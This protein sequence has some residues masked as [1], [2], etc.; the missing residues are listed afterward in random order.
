MQNTHPDTRRPNRTLT[1][2]RISLVCA[3]SALTACTPIDFSSL[4]FDLRGNAPGG[5]DTSGA[6]RNAA[7][8]DRP[9]P[10]DSGLITYPTYQVAVAKRGD[11]VTDVAAR[12][13]ISASEL[14]QFNGRSTDAP[15]RAGEILAMPRRVTPTAAE[16]PTEAT[17]RPDISAIAGA[18]IDRANPTAPAA[19][20]ATAPKLEV[21]SGKE[22]IRHRAARGE[23]AFTIARLY[24]VSVKSLAEW[25]GLGS[26]LEVR[27]GQYLIIPLILENTVTA[28]QAEAP[29]QGTATPV[30][31]SA[32]AALPEPITEAP[33][34]E[35]PQLGRLQ[36]PETQPAAPVAPTPAKP[37][38]AAPSFRKP[39]S[40]TLGSYSSKRQAVSIATSNG[41]AV[42][43]AA[44][45]EVILITRDVDQ[46]PVIV[47]AHAGDLKSVYANIKDARVK[48][49]DSISAGQ[50]LAVVNGDSF[51]FSVLRGV[52]PIDPTPLLR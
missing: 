39:V 32:A 35:S 26:D 12:V 9:K 6:A 22:P 49:G 17:S 3:V 11:T 19:P 43:A 1:L 21:Q 2:H 37:V 15:L 20:A 10:D 36:S 51:Q 27:E 7:I 45:G 42:S 24:G 29:G 28:P 13:G 33:L 47:V 5:L 46:N 14:A 8:A 16:A 31:P 4:D 34:P 52:E 38:T 40:G 50:R 23:T 44:A 30:P 41:A 48:K 18:A 25:N